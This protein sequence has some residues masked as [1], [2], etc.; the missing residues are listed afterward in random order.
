MLQCWGRPQLVPGQIM[1]LVPHRQPQY[2]TFLLAPGLS[3][4]QKTTLITHP[5]GSATALCPN[6]VSVCRMCISP[7]ARSS[8]DGSIIIL[9]APN[10]KIASHCSEKDGMCMWGARTSLHAV[11]P[12]DC[13]VCFCSRQLQW[14]W[15]WY[16]KVA[17]CLLEIL[18]ITELI[19]WEVHNPDCW[20]FGK[21]S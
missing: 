13:R 19:C 17:F 14:D 2:S 18:C 12:A 3:R 6:T 7:H 5:Q 16:W 8:R 1:H 20:S 21:G 9:H 15:V 10:T 11:T 4:E